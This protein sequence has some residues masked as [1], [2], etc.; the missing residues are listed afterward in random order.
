MHISVRIII[1]I[2]LGFR[3]A[4]LCTNDYSCYDRFSSC[5][6]LYKWLSIFLWFFVMHIYVRMTIHIL[7][8]FCHGH[9]CAN[10]YPYSYGISSCT[11]LYK[12][13]SIFLWVLAMHIADLTLGTCFHGK[14]LFCIFT[15]V[16]TFYW[17]FGK[18]WTSWIR[19]KSK[20]K[21]VKLWRKEKS[22]FEDPIYG[23]LMWWDIWR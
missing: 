15:Q 11:S 10:D 21:L 20:T 14:P 4:H 8:G 5:T 9:L 13:L 12:W 19:N 18:I 22:G 7:L 23:Y 17:R 3:H 1:H 2:L 6:S 16:P